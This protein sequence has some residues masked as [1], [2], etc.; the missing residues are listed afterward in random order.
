MPTLALGLLVAASLA[1]RNG[2]AASALSPTNQAVVGDVR[3][4]ALSQSLVR[5][6]IK[7]P[8]GFEDRATMNVVGRAE[9]GEGLPIKMLNTS[10]AGTWLATT[11]YHVFVPS[12]SAPSPPSSACAATEPGTDA[13][14]AHRSPNYPNGTHAAT[15]GACCAICVA[16]TLCQAWVAAKSEEHINCW[17]L[18][19]VAATQKKLL[20]TFGRVRG[21]PS[22]LNKGVIVATPGGKVLYHGTNTGNGSSVAANLLH[23]PSPLDSM[24][25]A[26]NDFPR[27]TVPECA[28]PPAPPQ[29][30]T[31][32]LGLL[33]TPA[34]QF[35]VWHLSTAPRQW[36]CAWWLL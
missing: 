12:A 15:A 17:P 26:F 21:T 27:F 18:A 34:V 28:R 30:K 14:D 19:R 22:G 7:G 1:R 13:M 10:A 16:D 33:K 25:Y 6:E 36:Y 23:W 32:L 5:V 4:S 11:A 20:R 24:A 31:D 2:A 8:K 35:S 9:F 3:V 29:K